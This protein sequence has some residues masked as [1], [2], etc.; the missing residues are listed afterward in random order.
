MTKV[1]N[2]F[3]KIFYSDP[4]QSQCSAVWCGVVPGCGWGGLGR[5]GG[6]SRQAALTD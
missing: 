4:T 5:A 1:G 3:C 2:I 6:G